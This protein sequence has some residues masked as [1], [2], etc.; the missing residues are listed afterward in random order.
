[1]KKKILIL[2]TIISTAMLLLSSCL[3]DDS[4]YVDFSKGGTFVDFPLGGFANFNA[5]AITEAP[6]A[7]GLIVRQFAVNV[8]SANLPT[9]PTTITL[10]AGDATDLAT[11]NKLQSNVVYE[12][13]PS[14]AYSIFLTK[15]TVA[16]GKQNALDSVKFD[17][18]K[19]DPSKSYVLPIKIT[20]G[21]G[22]KISGNLNVLYYHFIGND[23][24]GDYEWFFDRWSTPDSLNGTKDNNHVDEGLITFLPI[25]PT[26]FVVPTGY[27]T[28]PNYHVTFTKTGSGATATYSNFKVDFT[29]QD[30]LDYFVNYNPASPVTLV[31]HPE[32][33]PMNNVDYDPT[34]QYTFAQSLL[35]FRFYYTTASRAVIDTYVRP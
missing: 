34:K 21:G 7:N 19:L 28:H 15:V 11:I 8:A 30:I 25:T 27:Y 23:F 35:L 1:M 31:H 9:A 5:Q 3:K 2:T 29:P 16:A 10:A 17:K 26:E 32:I 33:R 22:Q 18:S 6:D 13:M 4:H 24:A 12:L 20:D 14:D